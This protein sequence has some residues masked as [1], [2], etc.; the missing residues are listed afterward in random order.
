MNDILNKVAEEFRTYYT[1]Y[2]K[3]CTST[4]DL[5][6]STG[7]LEAA[8]AFENILTKHLIREINNDT[9]RINQLDK[10]L[11]T[12]DTSPECGRAEDR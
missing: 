1:Q 10:L 5:Q 7:I 12:S 3:E 9:D 6:R 8:L 4:N 11:D 2:T